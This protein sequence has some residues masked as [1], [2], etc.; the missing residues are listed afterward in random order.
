MTLAIDSL[1]TDLMFQSGDALD[2]ETLVEVLGGQDELAK[3][4]VIDPD[5]QDPRFEM[6][7]SPSMP[8]R[9]RGE[10]R[11]MIMDDSVA[12]MREDPRADTKIP[13]DLRSAREHLISICAATPVRF[14]RLFALGSWGD[15]VWVTRSLRDLRGICLLSWVTTCSTDSYRIAIGLFS[16]PCSRTIRATISRYCDMFRW[17]VS[18]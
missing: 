18:S 2:P 13:L 17:S 10:R 6:E 8:F 5:M 11:L 1:V 3:K 15:A 14:G 16:K 9:R 12:P 7:L 4:Q